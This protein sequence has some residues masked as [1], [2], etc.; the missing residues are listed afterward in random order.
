MKD[1]LCLATVSMLVLVLS[2]LGGA[3]SNA[4]HLVFSPGGESSTDSWEFRGNHVAYP[5]AP[6]YTN[7]V[8]RQAD[9]GPDATNG[10]GA[11]LK[12][13]QVGPPEVLT[14]APRRYRRRRP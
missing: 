10:A 6:P 1:K 9:V 3:P 11:Q 5:L 13:K 8:M 14:A 4:N 2:G 12:K 7:H